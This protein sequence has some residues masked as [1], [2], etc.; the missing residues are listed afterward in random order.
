MV[1]YPLSEHT[2]PEGLEYEANV[3]T[4]SIIL[5]LMSEILDPFFSYFRKCNRTVVL[6]VLYVGRE[7]SNIR[8][9][10]PPGRTDAP[11]LKV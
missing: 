7:G 6:C 2:S 8:L 3:N 4:V 10:A 1:I 11:Y 9:N 5:A